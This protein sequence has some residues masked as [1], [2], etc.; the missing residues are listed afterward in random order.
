VF[1]AIHN[2]IIICGMGRLSLIYIIKLHRIN[3]FFRLLQ[4]NHG[5]L[6]NMFFLNMRDNYKVDDC[7][8]YIFY[9]KVDAASDVYGQFAAFVSYFH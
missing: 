2:L 9:N 4:L 7:L 3:F 1:E 6:F 5:L 8:S